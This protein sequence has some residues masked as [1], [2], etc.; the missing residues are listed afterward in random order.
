MLCLCHICTFCSPQQLICIQAFLG[1]LESIRHAI[2]KMCPAL[3]KCLGWVHRPL[4]WRSSVGSGIRLCGLGVKSC[5]QAWCVRHS[6]HKEAPGVVLHANTSSDVAVMRLR[7]NVLQAKLPWP[8]AADKAG[9][10]GYAA[11]LSPPIRASQAVLLPWQGCTITFSV[12][13]VMQLLQAASLLLLLHLAPDQLGQLLLMGGC[14]QKLMHGIDHEKE[15]RKARKRNDAGVAGCEPTHH[16][17]HLACY[18]CGS[19]QDS[20]RMLG[21]LLTSQRQTK[22]Q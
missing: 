22:Q 4:G 11:I 13:H 2:I 1:L 5:C 7:T 16:E 8:A 3:T 20:V 17:S 12:H 14:Q 19:L 9:Q 6:D 21:V 15:V 18:C 10:T